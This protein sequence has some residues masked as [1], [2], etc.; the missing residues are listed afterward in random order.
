MHVS[1]PPT[2]PAHLHSRPRCRLPRS[3]FLATVIYLPNRTTGS[4]VAVP[5]PTSFTL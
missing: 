3:D 1:R 2:E 4:W 5:C